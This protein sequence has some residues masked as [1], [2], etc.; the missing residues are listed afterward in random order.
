MR[1]GQNP[2]KF[3]KTVAQP[4]RITVAVLNYIPM[5]S[6]YYADLLNVLK[7]HLSS[8]RQ[9]AGL[10]FDLMLF[11][12]GSCEEVQEFLLN[13]FNSGGIDY[14]LLSRKNLG[15]GGAW[16]LLFGGA[17]GEIIAYTDNDVLFS[18]G[19]LKESMAILENYPNVGM[20]TARPF[21]TNPEF[22]SAT[23]N[24]ATGNPE[25]KLARGSLVNW[26][27]FR[28]FDLSLGQS[29]EEIQKRFNETED[30]RFEYHGIQAFAGASHWQFTA[31]KSVLQ[32]YLP[33]TMDRPMGQVKQLDQK[34]NNEGYLR[35]MTARPLAMNMSNQ[36]SIGSTINTT[37][38]KKQASSKGLWGLKP[39]KALLMKVYNW[40]FSLYYRD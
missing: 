18:N 27:D 24:W 8:L 21:R 4:E 31:Y 2:A 33:F 6:G 36:V 19:W 25:V 20:V 3:V 28:D 5:L 26:E 10:P 35:L 29:L 17:P 37:G 30:I 16:N 38:V 9:N 39:I 15:K 22:Y 40:I 23:V 13:E 12:N 32:K 14:L 1:I 11:D 34:M 7:A